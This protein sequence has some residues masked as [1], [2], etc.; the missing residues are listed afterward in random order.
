[1]VQIMGIDQATTFVS[2]QTLTAVV[3]KEA[4]DHAQGLSV[5]VYT[6]A[7]GGGLSAPVFLWVY[8]DGQAPVTTVEGLEGLWHRTT[9]TFTL[10]AHDQGRGVQ[11]TFWR[12]GTAG[13]YNS[14]TTVTVRAPGNHS[15]DGVHV[16]QFFSVDEVLNFESPPKEVQ[17]A[18]DTRPPTTCIAAATVQRGKGM[19]PKYMVY[20]A[21]S[22]KARDA[23]LQVIDAKGKIVLR[24]ALGKPA[25]RR[26]LNAAG[27]VVDLP[28]GT[29]KMRVLAHDLAGNAQSSTKSGVLTVR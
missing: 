8:E 14:G 26:W 3:P 2:R 13:D 12:V 1:V 9:A 25:T 17:V 11:N 4:L 24:Y 29:Y 5:R 10:V 7:P 18:I 6:P 21:L 16:I 22:P 28:A 23:L 27:V 15:N 19:T 20:D